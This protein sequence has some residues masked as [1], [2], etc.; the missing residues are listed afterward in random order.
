MRLGPGGSILGC[1]VGSAFPFSATQITMPRMSSR[2]SATSTGDQPPPA[3][4]QG[5][6][7]PDAAAPRARL[8]QERAL[9]PSERAVWLLNQ[10]ASLNGAIVAHVAGPL[11]PESVRAGLTRLQRRH[12]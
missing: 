5:P 9:S 2:G 12:P 8:V 10:A 3:S 1:I 7:T 11:D 4:G 6:R